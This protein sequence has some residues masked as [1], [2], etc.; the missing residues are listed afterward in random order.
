MIR[1]SKTIPVHDRD[2]V[3]GLGS[4]LLD[5]GAAQLQLWHAQAQHD[6]TMISGKELAIVE[7]LAGQLAGRAHSIYNPYTGEIRKTFLPDWIGK[8]QKEMRQR[9]AFIERQKDKL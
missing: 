4:C 7:R 3:E 5:P 6:R 1:G 2:P 8:W 9:E